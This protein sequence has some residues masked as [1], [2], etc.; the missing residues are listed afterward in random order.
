MRELGLDM[1]SQGKEQRPGEN[2]LRDTNGP[3]GT[4]QEHGGGPG[5]SRGRGVQ[6]EE[7][8]GLQVVPQ[9]LSLWGEVGDICHH[10]PAQWGAG[11]AVPDPYY[12]WWRCRN[13]VPWRC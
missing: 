8:K 2:F 9:P 13:A 1:T 7:Q 6:Q 4:K 3:E 5:P 12:S 11:V 10:V